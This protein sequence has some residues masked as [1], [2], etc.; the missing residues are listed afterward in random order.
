MSTGPELPSVKAILRIAEDYGIDLT[1]ED[2]AVYRDMMQPLVASYRRLEELPER[3]LPV[4]YPRTSGWRPVPED[5]PCNGWYW[6]C[7]VEG[8]ASGPLKGEKVALKDVVCLAGVPM[9]N[10]SQLLEGYVPDIDATIVT[11]LLDAGAIIIG[12]TNS[13]DCS[14]SGG[15]HTCSHGPVGNPRMPTHNPGASSNGSAVVLGT[16]QVDLAIGGDQGGSIRIPAAW[17]GVYGLKPTYGLVPY[18]GCAMIE[19][20]MDHIGPM[21]NS[22]EGVAKLLSA[23][24]GADPLDPR[25]RGVIPSDYVAD[26]MPALSRGVRGMRIAV[27][28]EGFA[29]KATDGFPPSDEMVDSRVRAAIDQLGRLGAEIEEVSIPMHLDALHIWRAIATEGAAEFMLKGA[30]AGTNWQGYYNTGLSEAFARGMRSRP[31]DLPATVRSVLF[32]G[33][34][35]KRAYF[36]RYYGKAQNLRHLVSEAYDAVLAKF[37]LLAMPTTP[38]CAT[39]MVG[40]DASI[41]DTISS[42]LNMLRNTCVADLTGHPSMSVPCGMQKGLPIGLMLT[43]RQF[44]DATVIAASAAFEGIGDW[45]RM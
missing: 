9:M 22:T 19:T 26:Y 13:E 27:V 24:A 15:G 16:G 39:P 38:F 37:D 35:M 31:N 8:A 30:G 3:K 23:I 11:R 14:F 29:H 12:K 17:S 1:T 36:G 34:Y 33:E 4:K 45:M 2:A 42:G 25:Q 40:R 21:A 43:G 41:A 20:T 5:N 7:V 28:R 18:T 6:R 32:G 44:D 10:G